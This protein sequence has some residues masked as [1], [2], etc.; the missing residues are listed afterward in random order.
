MRPTKPAVG[1]KQGRIRSGGNASD[2][3]VEQVEEVEEYL[4]TANWQLGNRR[5]RCR[6]M[7]DTRREG[8]REGER[9]THIHK[10][11]AVHTGRPRRCM[12]HRRETSIV[13]LITLWSF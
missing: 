10:E 4:Q 8:R 7:L 9:E 12:R 11:W 5:V 13:M 3:E 1:Q 2:G 6:L